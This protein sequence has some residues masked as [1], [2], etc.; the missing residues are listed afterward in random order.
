[1]FLSSEFNVE[2]D[3]MK[4]EMTCRLSEFQFSIFRP[5]QDGI[6]CYLWITFLPAFNP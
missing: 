3:L 4:D 5:G 2:A 1:M 6:P